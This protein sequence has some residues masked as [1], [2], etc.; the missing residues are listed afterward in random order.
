MHDG[1]RRNQQRLPGTGA[2]AHL[3]E[4]AGMHA[5]G[6]VQGD[7][8]VELVRG[9]VGGV[10][11]LPDVAAAHGIQRRNHH[12]HRVAH[13][14]MRGGAGRHV[15]F[16]QELRWVFHHQ[17]GRA[18]RGHVA[19]VHRL[20]HHDAGDRRG[21]FGIGELVF[22]L[23]DAGL[24]DLVAQPDLV[25]LLL[26]DGVLGQQLAV[27]L[28]VGPGVGKVGQRLVQRLPRVHRIHAYEHLA[29]LH[30]VALAGGDFADVARQPRGDGHAVVAGDDAA[31]DVMLRQCLGREPQRVRP[32]RRVRLVHGRGFAFGRAAGGEQGGHEGRGQRRGQRHGSMTVIHWITSGVSWPAAARSRALAMVRA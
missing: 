2:E 14:E 11:Q 31:G 21:D 4:H 27:A 30:S 32:N 19:G 22:R 12:V 15:G 9:R 1:G 29:L 8:H 24:G 20:L 23:L 18:G 25:E 5:P 16:H 28:Q 10:H 3:G 7:L 6:I 13:G 26:A 17:D